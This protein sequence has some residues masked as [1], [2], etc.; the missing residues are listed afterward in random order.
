VMFGLGG[1]YVEVL[2]DVQFRVAPISKIEASRMMGEINS[3][4]VLVGARGQKRKDLNAL[5]DVIYKVS[6]L[7]SEVD[8]ISEIDLNPIKA[9][10]QGEGCK[11][12]DV[13]ITLK[14]EVEEK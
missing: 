9:F 8:E 1:V 12:V 5:A 3:F 7:M 14:R 11:A 10:D 6:Y 13:A 2:K 4:P